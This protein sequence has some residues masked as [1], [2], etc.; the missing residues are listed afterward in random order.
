VI[1]PESQVEAA[2][3]PRSPISSEG[4]TRPSPA[5]RSPSG[6][7]A[8]RESEINKEL[9]R[10]NRALR[11]LSACNQALAQ[12][13]SEQGLL[14]QI[15]DLIV[16]LGEYRLAW[17]GYAM[18]DV[19]KTVRVMAHAG[20]DAGILNTAAV[21][22]SA[23]KPTGRGSVGTAIRDNR[24]CLITD[25]QT[26]PRF[27]P[28]RDWARRMGYGAL[29]TFPLR[30]AG[31]PFGS[32][33]IYA[34]EAGSFEGPEVQLLEEIAENLAYGITA[35][36]T[37]EESKRTEAALLE[38]EARY[39][40]L[41][42][43]VPAISYL[44]EA[45]A[46]GPF[47]YVSPQVKKILGYG[48][49]ECMSNSMFW[50]EHLHPDDR[51]VATTE[52]A[53]QE[54]VPFQFE[55]RMI[56]RDGRHVWI[57][58][59]G[60]IFRS[61][62]TGK[63]MARGQMIDI[64]R[65]KE[66]EEALRESEERYRRFVNES[67]E[68]IYRMEYDP[69]VPTHLS[70]EE[71]LAWGYKTGYMAECNDAMA[72]MYGFASSKEL[73]GKKLS[74]FLVLHDPVTRQFIENYIRNGYRIANQE[75]REIDAHG[76]KRIF[77]NTMVGT[78]VNGHWVRDWGITRDVTD[79][80]QMEEQLR[81]AQQLE[82][83]GRL[84]GG[85]AHDFN[86]ILSIII[87]HGELLLAMG[88]DERTR[89]GIQQI[90]RAA[91]RAASLTQQLLAFGRKQVLQPTILDL[92]E[93]VADVQKM[94]A[95]VIGEDIELIAKLHP[96]LGTAKADAGQVEQVLMNLAINARDAMPQGGRLTMETSNE[97]ITAGRGRDLDLA[98]G[99]YVMLRVSDTGHGMDAATLSH[100]FEP[101][102]TTKPVGKGTGLGLATVYGIVKQSGGSIQVESEAG[103]GTEFRIYLPAAESEVRCETMGSAPQVVAGGTET[104]LIAEDEKDL[105]ALTRIFL[106]SYGY[107]VVEAGG[108]EE[109]IARVANSVGPIHLLLTDV[110][111]PGMSG[112]Q[113]A[114]RILSEHPRT[115]ILYMTG[116]TDE[117]VA[118]HRLLESGVQLLQ[119]P[120]TKQELAL[121]VRAALDGA[122]IRD[123][124]LEA[125][126]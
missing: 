84:A 53:W 46:T 114:E 122:E 103:Q 125:R 21:N 25:T 100:I 24:P 57:R 92:N 16:R 43:E 19:A 38:A 115:R 72:R 81:N 58:D 35:I 97:E 66:A 80:M 79:Q 85:V 6:N 12:A 106:E 119:K 75:S 76:R 37:R 68:G 99:H 51:G 109:A 82:A 117:M 34:R 110:I 5:L 23:D 62:D 61:A 56:H 49:E 77:R 121:K 13:G 8:D 116:Y 74:E 26:D 90:Q 71:Q 36:R 55:Y 22:W 105:R 91:E 45:G 70:I 120:F 123:S 47:F 27:E 86:N 64:T 118:Q 78:V 69:P 63:R 94:L 87:G 18:P 17:I 33:T 30:V 10:L 101:F 20:D 52:D 42:E 48:P 39:R 111:M 98:P 54:G 28:W 67:S 29:I 32:L 60:T 96:S 31:L 3:E 73:E 93:A 15:C 112:R 2:S 95:R 40:L 88:N 7:A 44:A 102:F 41:V 107:R 1:N 108:A 124:G 59:E 126:G 113:L 65:Q 4:T 89:N 9:R 104:I 83:I 14:D 11:A 50:W